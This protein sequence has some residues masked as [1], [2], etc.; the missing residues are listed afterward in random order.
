MS[1]L[2]KYSKDT[3]RLFNAIDRLVC[4]ERNRRLQE[5]RILPFR[6]VL[7]IS[8]N[9]QRKQLFLDEQEKLIQLRLRFPDIEKQKICKEGRCI[10]KEGRLWSVKRIPHG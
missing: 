10:L 1:Y 2:D 5:V 6:C 7:L 3:K 8:F 4:D 9:I